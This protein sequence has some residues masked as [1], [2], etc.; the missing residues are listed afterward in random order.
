MGLRIGTVLG[1]WFQK[2]SLPTR[3]RVLTRFGTSVP[4]DVYVWDEVLSGFRDAAGR[5]R[6]VCPGVVRGRW[7]VT[8][9]EAV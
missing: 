2:G 6:V 9:G 1:G 4:G 8:F 5:D 7:G 3:I